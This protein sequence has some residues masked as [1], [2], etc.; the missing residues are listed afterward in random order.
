[1][2]QLHTTLWLA[3]SGMAIAVV[4]GLLVALA[5]HTSEA[6][7]VDFTVADTSD[8]GDFFLGNGVCESLTT[9][10]TPPVAVPGL[11]TLRAAVQEANASPGTD[12][13]LIPSGTYTLTGD[14]EI[15]DSV[16]IMVA[17]TNITIDGAGVDRIFRV[18]NG[19][20]H[21]TGVTLMN[22]AT[23]TG[24]AI[25]NEADLTLT[26]VTI[27]N[28]TA[29]RGGA[30]SNSVMG[31][32]T[33]NDSTIEGNVATVEG[34]AIQNA[35]GEVSITNST[36]SNNSAPAGGALFSENNDIQ[37][38]NS[39]ISGNEGGAVDVEDGTVALLNVT[40]AENNGA[41]SINLSGGE[42]SA[43]NSI[44]GPNAPSDCSEPI[45][46]LTHNIDSDNSCG[47]F[48]ANDVPNV[49][50][51]LGPLQ[52][53]GGDTETH[54]LLPG[55]PAINAGNDVAASASDQRGVLRVQ[56]SD[57]GAYEFEDADGD[58][59]G[60]ISGGGT[61]CDDSDPDVFPGAPDVSVD[62]KDQ[63]CDGIDGEVEPE[64]MPNGDGLVDVILLGD[65]NV[66][67]FTGED[68]TDPADLAALIG[69]RVESIW[70]YLAGVQVWVVFRP[71]GVAELNTLGPIAQGTALF[72]RLTAGEPILVELPDL[73]PG[74]SVEVVLAPLWN[75]VGYTGGAAE[76]AP[77]LPSGIG[78]TFLYDRTDAGWNGFFPAGPS[79]ANAFTEVD[80]LAA[81]FVLNETLSI[82]TLTWEQTSITP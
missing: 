24:G 50:P 43:Q 3:V 47:F 23:T 6:Q 70:A 73:L 45:T 14:I 32:L 37:I 25:R 48:A 4:T 13:I 9:I 17:G 67:V 81:L 27:I 19:T 82:V 26:N 69:P 75:F 66:L 2:L 55:S 41:P 68:E 62:G 22:G 74:G 39:T 63:D 11:C 78:A 56:E 53:N 61:D 71:T 5:I 77:L 15:S 72:V 40:V 8:A 46:N 29:S 30:I 80:R 64:P 34:G 60:P 38:S 58:G 59:V 51:L 21:I 7:A 1:M 65:W 57:I 10:G 54:S 76:I 36:L 31:T 49:D 42:A 20:V 18:T 44:I 79:I 35:G 52:D 28:G 12:T 16:V 33:I